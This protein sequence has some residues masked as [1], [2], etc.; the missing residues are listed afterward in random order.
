MKLKKAFFKQNPL[1]EQN[2]AEEIMLGCI[3]DISSSTFEAAQENIET[4]RMYDSERA[5]KMSVEL[6]LIKQAQ[7]PDNFINIL[8]KNNDFALAD[9]LALTALKYEEA[10]LPEFVKLYSRSLNDDVIDSLTLMI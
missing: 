4:Y 1:P 9:T 8:R 10:V 6:E 5:D 7:S 3:E 2:L